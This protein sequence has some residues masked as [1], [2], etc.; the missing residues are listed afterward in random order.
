MESKGLYVTAL[1]AAGDKFARAQPSAAMWNAAKIAVPAPGS[2]H[3]GPWVNTL[4]DEVMAFT[5]L[6]DA[7]DDIVDALAALHH[8][9]I[10]DPPVSMRRY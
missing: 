1:T 9:L 3:H 4:L 7:H 6:G 5:G 8:D 2:P 10:V